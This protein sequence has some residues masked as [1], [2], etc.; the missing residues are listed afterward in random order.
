MYR[1][2]VTSKRV[3]IGAPASFVWSVLT[4]FD[5][6]SQWN[7]FT[8]EVQ[9]TLQIGS[10]ARLQV[11]MWPGTKQ[12]IETLRA[13]EPPHLM[14]WQ[15]AFPHKSVLFAVRDQ[16]IESD[17][18]LSCIYHNT[19]T[20]TGLIAPIIGPT[21]GRYMEKGFNEV[22]EAL[23]VRAESLYIKLKNNEQ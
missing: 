12:I 20:L 9:T 1:Y 2:V 15:K 4:D 11:R 7:P 22:G 17:S 8:P 21:F 10:P 18:Q 14:S 3:T 16:I 6:Y 23:K 19:D 5:S 13:V